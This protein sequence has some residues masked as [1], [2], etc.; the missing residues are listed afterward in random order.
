MGVEI[1]CTAFLHLL[2]W[3]QTLHL[4]TLLGASEQMRGSRT[5]DENAFWS[6][7]R[8]EANIGIISEVNSLVATVLQPLI[9]V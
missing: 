2:L 8:R 5:P 9:H 6:V 1:H 3:E 4:H 7:T